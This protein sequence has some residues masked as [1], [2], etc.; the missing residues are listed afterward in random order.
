M[1]VLESQH[2]EWRNECNKGIDELQTRLGK[3]RESLSA[4]SELLGKADV[5]ILQVKY[6][7]EWTKQFFETLA[8]ATIC[9]RFPGD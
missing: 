8:C 1:E 3:L 5:K 6:K 2:R 7:D 4:S 9:R